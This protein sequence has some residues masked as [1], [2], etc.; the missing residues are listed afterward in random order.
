MVG[1]AVVG[2]AVAGQAAL[3]DRAALAAL[4]VLEGV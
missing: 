1:R 4:E 2:Q 3:V